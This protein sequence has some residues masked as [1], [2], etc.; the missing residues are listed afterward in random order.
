[1]V[2]CSI[3]F[4]LQKVWGSIV[5]LPLNQVSA[6]C[7]SWYPVGMTTYWCYFPLIIRN[8][9]A[10]VYCI[11]TK[12]STKMCH[13]TTFLCTK[14]Q[15]NRITCFYFMVTL[16]PLLKE[17]KDE[18]TKPVFG[19]SYLGNA[20]RDLFKI[21]NVG[22]WRWR[23]FPQQ[24]SSSFM[25]AAQSYVYVKIASLFFL[26]IYSQVLCAGFLGCTTH[27]RVSWY[28]TAQFQ[29]H[30]RLHV[31]NYTALKI[32]LKWACYSFPLCLPPIMRWRFVIKTGVMPIFSEFY[33][34]VKS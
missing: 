32:R 14:F 7:H 11:L 13:Y 22:Y 28:G 29:H 9:L 27:Y 6:S 10:S 30:T 16:T 33:K 18:E 34:D 31:C 26:L 25:Q 8:N 3:S 5:D 15:S 4:K 12:L 20:R 2:F 1:M 17:E 19:S 23:A 24:K 21:W